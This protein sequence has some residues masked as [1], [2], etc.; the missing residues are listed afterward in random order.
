[1]ETYSRIKFSLECVFIA[2][3]CL[4]LG[5]SGYVHLV[6]PAKFSV[7]IGLYRLVPAATAYCIVL[8]LPPFQLSIAVAMLFDRYRAAA[9]VMAV[10][11]FGVFSFA[12]WSVLIRGMTIDCGCF[13]SLSTLVSVR[14]A[15]AISILFFL[16]V[17]LMF[18]PAVKEPVRA[19]T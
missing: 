18:S 14:S 13:G 19:S 1:V 11:L 4:L 5:Y 12:Q 15:S 3:S 17:I 7:G 2:L 8:L 10:S 6:N 9:I 16:G